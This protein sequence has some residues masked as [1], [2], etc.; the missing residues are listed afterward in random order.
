MEYSKEVVKIGEY[1]Y[2]KGRIGWKGLKKSE[3]LSESNYRIINGESLESDG[4]NWNR[5]GYVSEERYNESPDIMLKKGDILIS[6]DGTI[7]KIGYVT[8][9]DVPT[10]VASGI[11]VI[12]NEKEDIIDTDFLYYYFKSNYFKSFVAARTEGSVIPHLYQKDFVEM[13]FSLFDLGIQKKASYILKMLDYRI[14]NNNLIN[15]KLQSISQLLFKQWFIDFEFPNEEGVPYKSSGGEMV[16]SELGMIPN[17]W[18]V[19]SLGDYINIKHGYAFKSKYF[20]DEETERILLTPGNFKTGGGFLNKKFKYY[21]IDG[22][23]KED[24]ILN[25]SDLI[26]TMTDLSKDGDT[27]GYPAFIPEFKDKLLLHNQRLGKVEN[28]NNVLS[29]SYIYMIMCSDLYRHYI[30]ATATGSTVK[31]TAPKRILEYKFALPCN[32]VQLL[33]LFNNI[34]E[35]YT[36]K[37][38]DIISENLCLNKLRDLLL[39]KLMNGEIDLSNLEIN[40]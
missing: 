26:V 22:E 16:D 38:N 25:K 33:M 32:S 37:S 8:N 21:S 40:I 2:I 7:G 6:K 28:I 35:N 10:T 30:L 12:R 39:P 9:L 23:L 20:I 4:I 18:E 31:H 14:Q 34:I 29:K 1:L 15:N 3:Y 27:L 24:F 17:G 13:E 11:F 36:D 5:C 19:V